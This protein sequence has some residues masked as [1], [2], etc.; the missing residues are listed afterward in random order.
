MLETHERRAAT[1][2]RTIV[3]DHFLPAP[4]TAGQQFRTL[5]RVLRR[6]AKVIVAI[7]AACLA[8]AAAVTAFLPRVYQATNTVMVVAGGGDTLGNY[9]SAEN[10]AVAKTGSYVSLGSAPEVSALARDELGDTPVV[11]V[12]FATSPGTTQ[13]RVNGQSSTPAGAVRVADAYAK[14]LISHA[15]T[16]ESIMA[17]GDP[18]ATNAGSK[19]VQLIPVSSATEPSAPI[20]PSLKKNLAY[21]LL[22]G[23]ALAGT[24]VL[25]RTLLDRKVRSSESVQAA[26][27]LPVLGTIP[28]DKRLSKQRQVVSLTP[29]S[30]DRGGWATAEAVRE[31]RTNLTFANVDDPARSIVMTSS[32]PGEGKSLVA[33]NLAAAIGATGQPT[34][35]IDGDLRRP[36]QSSI[37][38]LPGSAGLTD[39]L[40][41]AVDL[42]DVLQLWKPGSNLYLL[43]AG[44]TP[45]NPSELLGSRR[46]RTLL[47][48]LSRSYFVI[49]DSPPIL[50]VTDAAVL[51]SSADGVLV[52]VEANRT[53]I[54]ALVDATGR[55]R[56]MNSNTLGVVLN[57]VPLK[58]SSASQYGYYTKSYYYTTTGEKKP[59]RAK[60]STTRRGA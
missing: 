14:A 24:F 39:L 60:R 51:S 28:S 33:A 26:T 11:N 1:P 36:M 29:S 48:E 46:M 20:S 35:L 41:G 4:P 43:N 57:Q 58:A 59:R 54:D 37:F 34:I 23:I 49:V 22:L 7:I 10:L 6:H 47:A 52:V 21:A 55:L 17:T 25:V 13:I 8:G 16:I 53:N 27:A 18:T 5:V 12:S 31:L 42:Q 44:R 9:L 30:R 50:P 19:L 3:S 56:K 32:L 38:S 45:P 15:M 2:E 40:S